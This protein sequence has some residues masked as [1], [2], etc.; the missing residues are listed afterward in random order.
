MTLLQR[1]WTQVQNVP[2]SML[3]MRSLYSSLFCRSCFFRILS[4]FLTKIII[5]TYLVLAFL[6]SWSSLIIIIILYN[7]NSTFS[8]WSNLSFAIFLNL[9]TMTADSYPCNLLLCI[10]HN[11]VCSQ[12]TFSCHFFGHFPCEHNW[13]TWIILLATC[14]TANINANKNRKNFNLIRR[15]YNIWTSLCQK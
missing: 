6:V 15:G 2:W 11:C 8:H 4:C 9:V 10:S 14:S 12:N 3:T 13:Y 7:N 5:I 1:W